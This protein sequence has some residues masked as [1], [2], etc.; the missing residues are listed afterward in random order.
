MQYIPY[1]Y[2]SLQNSDE[3][4]ISGTSKFCWH[5]QS[6]ASKFG[7]CR[8]NSKMSWFRWLS[9]ETCRSS[10]QIKCHSN[11][12]RGVRAGCWMAPGRSYGIVQWYYINGIMISWKYLQGHLPFQI[13]TSP[14]I[15]CQSLKSVSSGKNENRTSGKWWF[16]S[17]M[18]WFTYLFL[19]SPSHASPA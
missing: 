11:R 19:G 12:I 4:H 1:P 8:W 9:D 5:L 10:P 13:C 7:V 3:K 6:S 16:I 14:Q 17:G 18:P 15:Y 2:E